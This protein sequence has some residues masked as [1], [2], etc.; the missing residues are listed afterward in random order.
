MSREAG[1]MDDIVIGTRGR[2]EALQLKHS[3][4]RKSITLA[5]LLKGEDRTPS[6][7]RAMV[8]GWRSLTAAHAPTQVSVKLVFR[9]VAG[10]LGVLPKDAIGPEHESFQSFLQEGW[11]P[12]LSE[13]LLTK[14]QSVRDAIVREGQLAP[15]EVARFFSVSGVEFVNAQTPLEQPW[16]EVDVQ[17]LTEY[18]MRTASGDVRPGMIRLTALLHGLGWEDRFQTRF[19]HE[20]KIDARY[21]A[22]QA[23][24][25]P[26][27]RL[28][29]VGSSGYAALLGTP[30]SGKSTTLAHTLRNRPEWRFIPYFAFIPGDVAQGR[31]EAVRFLHDL[32][33]ALHRLNFRGSRGYA[34]EE[35]HSLQTEL[36]EIFTKLG[37]DFAECGR[38]TV[39]LVDGLDHIERE[40]RPALSLISMLP[41]PDTIPSGVLFVL[42]SQ[43]LELDKLSPAIAGQLG[44]EGRTVRMA[45]MSKPEIQGFLDRSRLPVTIDAAKFTQIQKLSEGHP[46][47]LALLVERLR[48]AVD[49]ASL[50]HLLAASPSYDGHIERSYAVFWLE[51]KRDA[52]TRHLLARWARLHGAWALKDLAEA[53]G[54]PAVEQAVSRAEPYLRTT[55][56]GMVDFF[57]NSFRQFV[58]TATRTSPLGIDENA[59]IHR[60]MAHR[61]AE[62]PI[63][64][65]LG[66]EAIRHA[67]AAGDDDHVLAW[68]QADRLRAQFLANRPSRT[69]FEDIFAALEVAKKRKDPTRVVQILLIWQE[70]YR[71]ARALEAEDR[72]I[73]IYRLWGAGAVRRHLENEGWVAVGT[74][75]ALRLCRVL[76]EAGEM[77]HAREVYDL[78]EPHAWL[79]GQSEVEVG[80][81]EKPMKDL[82]EWATL[83][84]DFRSLE[85]IVAGIERLRLGQSPLHKERSDERD[86]KLRVSVLGSLAEALTDRDDWPAVEFVRSRVPVSHIE[87]W[88]NGLDWHLVNQHPKH[89]QTQK[90]LQRLEARYAGQ[91]KRAADMAEIV[92]RVTADAARAKAWIDLAKQPASPLHTDLYQTS[93]DVSQR[94]LITRMQVT[95]GLDVTLEKIVPQNSNPREHGQWLFDR[96]LTRLAIL[97]GN[98]RAGKILEPAELKSELQPLVRLFHQEYEDSR[99]WDSW[100]HLT[101]KRDEFYQWLVR[102]VATHGAEAVT[103]L[104][105]ELDLVWADTALVGYW[106]VQIRRGIAQALFEQDGNR[107][108]LVRRL[109]AWAEECDVRY[110]SLDERVHE[111]VNVAET[112]LVAGE[113]ERAV[114]A[115]RRLLETSYGVPEKDG[116]TARHWVQ[117][118]NKAQTIDPS[119]LTDGATILAPALQQLAKM[120]RGQ[121]RET[122]AKDLLLVLA[123]R[124]LSMTH[125]VATRFVAE[126][127]L[128]YDAALAADLRAI[129][130]H[131]ADHAALAI[132]VSEHLLLPVANDGHAE[133][134]QAI[135]KASE[136]IPKSKTELIESLHTVASPAVRDIWLG[137]FGEPECEPPDDSY[138]TSDEELDRSFPDRGKAKKTWKEIRTTDAVL[139]FLNHSDAGHRA[140]FQRETAMK[141]LF[142]RLPRQDWPEIFA[143][144]RSENWTEFMLAGIARELQSVGLKAEAAEIARRAFLQSKAQGWHRMSD[145]GSRIVP[146]EIWV[147]CA[148]EE[149]RAAVFQQWVDDCLSGATHP[150]E[151]MDNL[152][153]LIALFM[154]NPPWPQFWRTL[155]GQIG[156]LAEF[157]ES[158]KPEPAATT[159]TTGLD[160]IAFWITWRAQFPASEL[161]DA[162]YRLL[163]RLS[164]EPVHHDLVRRVVD[165]LLNISEETRAPALLLLRERPA[166]A[167][168]AITKRVRELTAAP[169]GNTRS[170]A[171]QVLERISDGKE[172]VTPSPKPDLPIIYSLELPPIRMKNKRWGKE[173]YPASGPPRETEDRYEWVSPFNR[174]LEAL[175]NIS[176]IPHQNLVRRMSDLMLEISPRDR[177]S[178]STQKEM[179]EQMRKAELRLIHRH[180]R[181]MVANAAFERVVTEL[182]DGG[183]LTNGNF[184]GLMQFLDPIDHAVVNWR[185]QRMP[186]QVVPPDIKALW[187]FDV[188]PWLK[189]AASAIGQCLRK[190]PDGRVV[191]AELSRFRYFDRSSPTEVR[192][193]VGTKADENAPEW[194]EDFGFLPGAKETWRADQ[195]PHLASANTM[196]AVAIHG[197]SALAFVGATEWVALNPA[198]G[199]ALGWKATDKAMFGWEDEK[200]VLQAQTIWWSNG[201]YYRVD[202]NQRRL[203][204]QGWLVV[205]TPSAAEAL[206]RDF[207]VVR[208]VGVHRCISEREESEP[209]V[210]FQTEPLVG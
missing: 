122:A 16:A 105:Q 27:E 8:D 65:P 6:L 172:T 56:A 34:T 77:T 144:A 40:Q 76:A 118:W 154:S 10:G 139:E 199:E 60:E 70:F 79:S 178:E 44:L 138:S 61:F 95:L 130:R 114:Q 210:I 181:A 99:D 38:R 126:G 1:A 19:A 23:T 82:D 102:A 31:G 186:A 54:A 75:Q 171:V 72:L 180:L 127:V 80:L 15:D 197:R 159:E 89:A 24:T 110:E 90:S 50:E 74:N 189:G 133:L 146:A 100:H 187:T 156:V 5:S 96:A 188:T 51:L 167:T 195:Y 158:A 168:P 161:H 37:K 140:I 18:L 86:F 49:E 125:A 198:V 4:G 58:L 193:S 104:A 128:S 208:F 52:A 20:W 62:L 166:L 111:F 7:L 87:T 66:W 209:D 81:G 175:A 11:K 162:N 177:W 184:T 151:G 57:H 39:I 194:D 48:K 153:E 67:A 106:P 2:V 83:A 121:D 69:I 200:G 88:Q 30:G 174:H 179:M 149:A 116:G 53:F 173:M 137:Y 185:P 43:T 33:V 68:C 92:W 25:G 152:E 101:Y 59:T 41:H 45:P 207:A 150:P 160:A 113:N 190:L 120:R 145:G 155:A 131:E 32:V 136:S 103:V 183:K 164:D 12:E 47:A 123:D 78:T 129:V 176:G 112:W 206:V 205:V 85:D 119:V 148:G 98:G 182:A 147:E 143:A 203:S 64:A 192:C 29:A 117:W 169:G 141:G 204:S 109:G 94:L 84:L 108:A 35:Q 36:A 3:S 21:Q 26:L 107:A 196:N 157:R 163:L 97:W 93:T 46:L 42:G 165:Q 201:P 55:G 9:G 17:T 191:L 170:Y 135:A 202:Q 132:C 115:Y 124:N 91:A 22:I 142:G 13:V 14:W 134:G 73:L 63:H 71:R 28:L